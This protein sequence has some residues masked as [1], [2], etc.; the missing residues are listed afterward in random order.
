MQSAVQGPAAGSLGSSQAYSGSCSVTGISLAA[1]Q[2]AHSPGGQTIAAV[3]PF[4]RD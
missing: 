1:S 2:W 3:V 4:E